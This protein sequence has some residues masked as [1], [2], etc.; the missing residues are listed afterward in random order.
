ME[1]FKGVPKKR[2]FT[3]I[4]LISLIYSISFIFINYNTEFNLLGNATNFFNSLIKTFLAAGSIT[5]ITAL[6]LY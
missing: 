4:I 5:A 3:T 6:I 2:F 1:I